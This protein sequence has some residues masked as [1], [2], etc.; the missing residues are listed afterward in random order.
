MLRYYSYYNVG[1]YKDMFLGDSTMKIADTFYLPLLAIWEKK[2]KAGDSVLADKVKTLSELPSIKI[3]SEKN[4][5]GLSPKANS[6]FS[7][8]GYKVYISEL[9][10]GETVFAVR[11]I[12]G[13]AKDESGRA[14]P[15]L[16]V[17]AGD[18]KE[19]KK[20]LEKLAAY[21]ASHIES[22]S[23]FFAGLFSYDAEK[24]GVVFHL[25]K[26]NSFIEDIASKH[27]SIF[28]TVNGEVDVDSQKNQNGLIVIPKGLTEEVAIN[29]QNLNG[30]LFR[31]IRIEDVLPLD[32]Q[33]KLVS[34]LRGLKG[35]NKSIFSDKRIIYLIGGAFAIGLVLGLL[36]NK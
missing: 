20:R 25:S 15:F 33:K 4:Q 8:G 3:L 9:T 35:N 32:N 1:G 5:F 31:I 6:L 26:L 2:A 21:A 29:E 14:T 34:I 7:R 19:D 11:D 30:K 28:L 22:V 17:I 16:I 27:D 12:E 13:S 36:F 23:K 10:T 24:N 18:T